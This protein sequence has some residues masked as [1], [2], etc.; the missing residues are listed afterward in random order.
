MPGRIILNVRSDGTVFTAGGTPLFSDGF[1]TGDFSLWTGESDTNNDLTVVGTPVYAGSYAASARV[2]DADTYEVWKTLGTPV[3]EIWT[4]FYIRFNEVSSASVAAGATHQVCII[5]D[6]ALA[7]GYGEIIFTV[8]SASPRVIDQLLIGYKDGA[9]AFQYVGG[10]ISPSANQWYEV[11]IRHVKGITSNGT[12]SVWFDGTLLQ[13]V[14]NAD[15]HDDTEYGAVWLGTP[16][17]TGWG[18]WG[19]LFVYYDNFQIAESDIW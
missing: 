1:E 10:A 16:A 8:N 14:T 13:T 11:K 7:N 19:S 4:H 15:M 9:S 5:S 2:N 6:T 17:Y 12:V 3:N 18:G